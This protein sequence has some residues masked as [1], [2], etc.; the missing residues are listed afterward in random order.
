MGLYPRLDYKKSKKNTT[1]DDEVRVV[2]DYY[3]GGKRTKITTNVSCLVKNWD[4]NWRDKTSNSKKR[5][6]RTPT[7]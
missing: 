2:I 3:Y 7:P 1:K 5:Q 4:K 6:K